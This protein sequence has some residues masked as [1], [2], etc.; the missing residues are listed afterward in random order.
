MF[1]MFGIGTRY[2]VLSIGY[3]VYSIFGTLD[4]RY[5]VFGILYLLAFFL[6]ANGKKKINYQYSQDHTNPQ[7]K[8][9]YYKQAKHQHQQSP[10]SFTLRV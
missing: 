8:H 5:S 9:H 10:P 7:L 6:P 1:G 4:S 2:S 3:S